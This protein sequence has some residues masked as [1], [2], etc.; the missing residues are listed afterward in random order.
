M[1]R[2]LIVGAGQAGLQLALGLQSHGYDV[3]LLTDRD[4][5]EVRDGRVLSTQ[6]MFD[7][8]LRTERVQ[9]LDLWVERAPQI[10]GIGVSVAGPESARVVDWVGRLDGHAQSVD[11][12]LKMSTWLEL[13]AGRGGRVEVRQ[14]SAADLEHLSRSYD[15]TL[16]AAGKGALSSLFERD[17]ERSPYT[18]PQRALAVSYVH[19]LAPRP[20]H[21]FPAVR[22][23]LVP[24]VGELFVMPVL[25]AAGPC[26]TLFWEAVPGGP[27]DAFDGIR[28]P[29]EHL[30]VT[31]E[32]MKAFTPWE[33]DRAAS[34]VELTDAGATLAG[35]FAPV[36][37]RPVGE[38]PGGGAVL[39]MAD[40]VVLNDPITGQGANSAARCAAVYLEAI[41]AHGDRPF[42]REFLRSAF[43]RF[44]EAVARPATAWT[45]AMLA[46]PPPHV[47]ELLG[48]GGQLPAVADR[49]ANAFD[50]PADL[51]EWFFDPGRA[52]AYL[53]SVAPDG[54]TGR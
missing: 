31:L 42:D 3:T 11:Q 18:R 37:R 27:A 10:E 25:T 45:N 44:W 22:C 7:A 17:E 38:L 36:V 48:S 33:Y 39:G 6:C 34:G 1:R 28:D 49:F 15:L 2:V 26:D 40:V 16:V 4:A 5:Q 9:G 13:F 12:R 52:A 41:L 47:R 51:E 35:R 21:D 54:R 24:G 19:G 50:R 14:V 32:L 20:E 8:A 46:P 30:W 53:A 29:A 23:N 43:G